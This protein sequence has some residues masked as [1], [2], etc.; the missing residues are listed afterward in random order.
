M[1]YSI[2]GGKLWCA[3]SGICIV[4]ND[5]EV[6]RELIENNTKAKR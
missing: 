4:Y 6:I 3:S 2:I 1:S 5:A